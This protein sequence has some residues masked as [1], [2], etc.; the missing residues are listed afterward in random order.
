MVLG[1]IYSPW[2]RWII[3]C[4][5]R[6]RPRR[7]SMLFYR[8]SPTKA[9]EPDGYLAHEVAPPRV[10]V[11]TIN[12][13]HAHLCGTQLSYHFLLSSSISISLSLSTNQRYSLWSLCSLPSTAPQARGVMSCGLYGI[14]FGFPVVATMSVSSP[15]S[16]LKCENSPSKI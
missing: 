13:W 11:S 2:L 14:M 16:P 4:W 10:T 15:T 3:W 1:Q 12:V 7:W 8:C 9:L 5:L 6:I